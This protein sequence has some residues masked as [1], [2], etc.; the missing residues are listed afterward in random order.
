MKLEVPGK[1]ITHVCLD[2]VHYPVRDGVVEVPAGLLAQELERL[3]Y[4]PV[5]EAP[6]PPGPVFEDA[7][8]GAEATGAEATE[9]EAP[10]PAP[11]AA[12]RKK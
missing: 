6:P 7:A 8:L 12:K 3:G 10:A 2:G 4:Q 5:A 1:N 11:R 9:T